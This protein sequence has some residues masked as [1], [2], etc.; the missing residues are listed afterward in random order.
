M[1]TKLS[2]L[3]AVD[4][5]VA[6][7]IEYYG[8]WVFDNPLFISHEKDLDFQ[9]IQKILYRLICEFVQNYPKYEELMPI[10]DQAKHVL[11]LFNSRPYQT[12]TYR[13]DYVF[14]STGVPRLIEITCRF[15]LNGFFEAAVYNKCSQ[16]ICDERFPGLNFTNRY[17]ELYLYLESLYSRNEEIIIIKGSDLKNSS[18]TYLKIF[19]ATGMPVSEMHYSELSF[20][21]RRLK[22]SWVI[23]EL[24]LG[25]IEKLPD[26]VLKTLAE[27]NLIND[28]RTV[29]LIHD[30]RFFYVIQDMHLQEACLSEDDRLF[31]K[32]HLIPTYRYG[33]EPD[34]WKAAE[35]R[36][37]Q[38]I[39]KPRSLGK[40]KGI[41]AGELTSEEEWNRILKSPEIRDYILQQWIPQDRWKGRLRGEEYSDYITGTL[42]FLNNHYFGQGPLRA[43]SYPISNVVD[44]RKVATIAL[45]QGRVEDFAD[46]NFPRA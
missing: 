19:Q 39:L 24:T 17:E 36:R 20:N 5:F 28:F 11:Q 38:W 35:K 8:Q 30:K 4:L 9:R 26:C 15:A 2:L 6:E 46:F 3:Q 13:T 34:T 40:S 10:S 21:A 43:S 32:K 27:S 18:Q 14:D 12:G 44:D 45:K 42:L 1:A 29:F 22:K 7:K 31:F 41:Y 37:E 23:S 33:V 25:E 16:R